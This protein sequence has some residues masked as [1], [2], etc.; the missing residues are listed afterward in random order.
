MGY[1]ARLIHG[2]RTFSLNDSTYSVYG[3]FVP[4]APVRAV[5]VSQGTFRSASGGVVTGK[6]AIDRNWTFSVR[7]VGASRA[8]IHGAA[9]ALQSFLDLAGDTTDKLYFEYAPTDS[10]SY[11]PLWGQGWYRWHIK[12]GL[13]GIWDMYPVADLN[14]QAMVCPLALMIG[15]HNEGLK[16]R[17][18]SALGGIYEVQAGSARKVSRG[19]NIGRGIVNRMTN[20]VFGHGTF[21]NGWTAG[22]GLNVTQNT[23]REF[24]MFGTSSAKITRNAASGLTFTQSI[25]VGST[26]AQWLS[27]YVKK[28]DG[29]APTASDI[30]LYYNADITTTFQAMGDGWYLMYAEVT[31]INSATTTGVAIKGAAR[32]VYVDGFC[33]Q[34]AVF[35]SLPGYGDMLGWA[36]DGTAHA[37]TS[38]RTAGVLKWARDVIIDPGAGSLVFAWTPDAPSSEQ[39]GDV[40][41]FQTDP[42]TGLSFRWVQASDYWRLSD[43]TNSANSGATTYAAWVPLVFH[44]TWSSA[45]L[46]AYLNGA[47]IATNSTYTPLETGTSFFLGT[48]NGSANHAG[49]V[50][51]GMKAY[52]RAMSST[53][54]AAQYADMAQQLGGGDG[55]GERVDCIPWR[56]TKDGDDIVDNCDDSSRD[57]WF[58]CGGVPGD[59]YAKTMYK[60][61]LDADSAAKDL[62][63]GQNTG[64]Y[65]M[66]YPHSRFYNELQGTADAT[67][68]GGEKKGVAMSTTC[69]G[70]LSANITYP[71]W[72]END[73]HLFVR[74]SGSGSISV[75][76]LP[77]LKYNAG[78]IRGD[79]KL[80]AVTTTEAI[81]Y[82][83]RLSLAPELDILAFGELVIAF[84]AAFTA[85]SG[86]LNLD[87]VQAIN[88]KLCRIVFTAA[89]PPGVTDLTLPTWVKWQERESECDGS[90]T[91]DVDMDI[92][93][94]R[95]NAYN[96]MTLI[97]GTDGGAHDIADATTISIIDVTPRWELV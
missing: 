41:L 1:I 6:K 58:V 2:S 55:Y 39:N 36:W 90:Y 82:L 48:S 61:T 64:D 30:Q 35:F 74:S 52:A 29:S 70:E 72:L 14:G 24:I 28:P 10:V 9:N 88:G 62:Y 79:T 85:A 3:D 11:R 63:L 23:N 22:A 97:S 87:F 95:P 92:V 15:P 5:N 89:T 42:A 68:S 25:N 40:Y 13:A 84:G 31:G 75:T 76:G 46:F 78:Y 69:A 45:G 27:C 94:L 4:P 16:Q 56:W 26:N 80:M 8:E 81:W 67:C 49:G 77:Y 59:T 71:E 66:F 65:W 47:Q 21:D 18:G 83:G 60:L 37:S 91:S 93:N 34:T 73:Y 57:N 20:P 19:L 86:T 17:M 32:T 38:T 51:H 54:V 33:L 43:G 7:I 44:I 50:F 12:D 53:E 96:L